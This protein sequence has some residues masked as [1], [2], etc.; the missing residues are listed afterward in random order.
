[1]RR[2][3]EFT[4]KLLL[5]K[6]LYIVYFKYQIIPLHNISID[7]KGAPPRAHYAQQPPAFNDK[8]NKIK[9]RYSVY[10]SNCV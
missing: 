3:N 7:K 4:L 10:S 8:K 6:H 9:C 2:G 5:P 1:M